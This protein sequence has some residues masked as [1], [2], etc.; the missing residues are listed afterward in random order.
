MKK[1]LL[2]ALLTSTSTLAMA[3][4]STDGLYIQGNVGVSKLEAKVDGKKLKDN[5]T[6]YTVAVGKDMGAVRYQADYTNFGKIKENGSDGERG[7]ASYEEWKG[8]MKAQSLGLSAIYDFNTT[9]GLTPYAGVRVGVNQLKADYHDVSTA[10]SATGQLTDI[11]DNSSVKK[12]KVDAGVLAG[13]QYAFNPQ[14]AL[15]VGVEYNHLGKVKVYDTKMNQ[16]GAK[17]GLRYNF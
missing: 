16:Y 7:T 12:T 15:D 6:G 13:V 11:T 17:V 14:M 4:I 3:Q 9:A 10:I 2:A 5:G 8:T 1:L